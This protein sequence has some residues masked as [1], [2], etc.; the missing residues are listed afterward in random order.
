MLKGQVHR[1]GYIIPDDDGGKIRVLLRCLSGML[2][3]ARVSMDHSALLSQKV[4]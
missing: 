2:M 3:G 4:Y 1:K